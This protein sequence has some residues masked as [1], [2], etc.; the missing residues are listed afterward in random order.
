MA[1]MITRSLAFAS[2]MDAANQ[3]MRRR[4]AQEGSQSPAAWNAEEADIATATTN[5]L[6]LYVPFAEG[7]LGGLNLSP[8]QRAEVAISEDAW[9]RAQ[10]AAVE[11]VGNV[12]AVR[13]SRHRAA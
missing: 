7:G 5:R 3:A 2:G 9:E 11:M 12:L 13:S 1:I 4:L 10:E 6:L 8:T